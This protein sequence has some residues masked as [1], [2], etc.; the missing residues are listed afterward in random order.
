MANAMLAGVPPVYGLYSSLY[1]L[2]IYF[3][4][5]TSRHLSIGTF[6]V[7]AIIIGS[8]TA[9]VEQNA[10][11][12]EV[13]VETA[14]V[15]MAIQ[16]T[17]MCGLIQLALLLLV[18]GG[19]VRWLSASVIRAYVAA[20]GMHVIIL[21]LPLMM[22]L[23]THR[24]SGLLPSLWTLR[25]VLCGASSSLPAALVLS[26][27][28]IV[29]LIGGKLLNNRFKHKLPVAMPWE[30]IMIIVSTLVSV[31]MD[32]SGSYHVQVVGHIPSGLSLPSLPC[33][34]SLS[35]LLL[36]AL[37]AAL[38]GFSFLSA[39]GTVFA[40][41]HGYK[42][43]HN[44]ELLALGLCNSVGSMFQ[45]FTVSCSFSRSTVQ[46]SIGVKTQV[47]GLVSAS[48]ILLILLKIGHLFEQLPKCVLAAVIV[49]NLQ[50]T[51]T[52][53]R[54][55]CELWRTDRTDLC[56]WVASFF[57]TLVFNLD[58][59]LAVSVVISLLS[60]LYR[61]QRLSGAPVIL[62]Q[63]SDTGLYRDAKVFSQAKLVPGVSVLSCP[64]SLY[65][66]NSDLIFSSVRE[67]IKA[68]MVSPEGQSTPL[69]SSS[70]SSS[71]SPS[72]PQTRSLVLDF[73]SVQFVDS[74]A[75]KA[76]SKVMEE[77][78]SV[79]GTVVIAAC[80]ESVL[81]QMRSS[82]SSSCL[83]PSVHFA[84]QHCVHSMTTTNVEESNPDCPQT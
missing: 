5:G 11:G 22:G 52:Q 24:Y 49:V 54:D 77:V 33:L 72:S 65:F 64:G 78:E 29:V 51:V 34:S 66:V 15:N 62:G 7:L 14:K 81:T 53:L 56:V 37:S 50:K 55:V 35:S 40:Q 68:M 84:V 76:L 4:F 60:V 18:G 70:S 21:Q 13:D 69:T 80:S 31:Q 39:L 19:V 75:M 26:S 58:L 73:S 63:I 38:V 10:A 47:A 74:V 28:S 1:P 17:F 71:S 6:A 36:P 57:S 82:V 43:N 59:G 61:T 9:D 45:C 16:L 79:G 67:T 20:G 41:K 42:V 44:Q 30:L 3:I 32:L 46:D 48:M 8:V 23:Q 25:D 12:A 27:V 2:I 83:F